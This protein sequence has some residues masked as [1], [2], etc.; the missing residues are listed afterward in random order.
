M[1]N[2]LIFVVESKSEKENSDGVYLRETLDYFYDYDRKN[3]IIKFV[4]M[5]G[6]HNYKKKKV[7][8]KISCYIRQSKV[9]DTQVQCKVYYMFD[10]DNTYLS[11][12]D[13]VFN[14]EVNKYCEEND[15]TLIWMNQNI[16]DVYLNKTVEHGKKVKEAGKFKKRNAIKN[17]DIKQLMNNN[18]NT[19]HSSNI[20]IELDKTLKRK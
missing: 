9:M 11:N 18:A 7:E 6:K 15:Y 10:K 3:T 2:L 5:N 16:E 4:Y 12:E 13:I 17:V 19:R 8:Q 20:L 1:R 14:K